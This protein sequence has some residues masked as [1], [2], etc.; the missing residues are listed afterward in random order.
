SFPPA[1]R[2]PRLLQLHGRAR[3][4]GHSA[5]PTRVLRGDG[6]C[7]GRLPGHRC[8]GGFR[9]LAGSAPR[10]GL[11]AQV[12]ARLPARPERRT[13]RPWPAPPCPRRAREMARCWRCLR[14]VCRA[15]RPLRAPGAKFPG[16]RRR[17][18]IAAQLGGR[19]P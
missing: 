5:A 2:R 9:G 16:R 19:A 3:R 14:L 4:P 11:C 13:P 18:G 12:A 7:A 1:A 15:A 10:L 17:F 8:P 6:R